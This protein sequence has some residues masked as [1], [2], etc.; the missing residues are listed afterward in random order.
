MNSSLICKNV[1]LYCR[2]ADGSERAILKR[3]NATLNAGQGIMVSGVTGAGKSTLLHLFA[4]LLRPSEGRIIVNGQPVSRWNTVHRDRWRR[5][6][7]IVFQQPH[8]LNELT[9]FENVFFR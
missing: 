5:Q 7:G 3:V 4:G 6:V 9:V 8:L 1:S 2:R